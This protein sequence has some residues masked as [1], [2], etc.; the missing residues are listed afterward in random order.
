V[1]KAKYYFQELGFGAQYKSGFL[2]AAVGVRLDSD[3]DQGDSDETWTLTS[4]GLDKYA[5]TNSSPAGPTKAG[6]FPFAP[7]SAN[8]SWSRTQYFDEG[9]KIVWGIEPVF[10]T[11]VPGLTL[12][13]DGQLTGIGAHFR[14]KTGIKA[15]F[16]AA[17]FDASVG[18]ALETFEKFDATNSSWDF[19]KTGI[20]IEP[21]VSYQVF[22]WLKP[23]VDALLVFAFYEDEVKDYYKSITTDDLAGFDM[24]RLRVFAE[25]ALGNGITFTPRYNMTVKPANSASLVETAGLTV[26]G[27]DKNRIEN[28]FE[29]RFGYSF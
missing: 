12:K 23:G 29:L 15:G 28:R 8:T 27:W 16:A 19:R 3:G 17:G 11:L 25:M 22:S 13:V 9:T 1:S 20:T 21:A 24:F 18:A 26:A 2:N 4:A 6:N 14:S 5:Q 7:Y 10:T